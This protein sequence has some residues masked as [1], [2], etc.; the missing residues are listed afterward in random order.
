MWHPYV[1]H[2]AA[3]EVTIKIVS[4]SKIS[5]QDLLDDFRN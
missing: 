3:I 5:D 4:K 1:V 2:L